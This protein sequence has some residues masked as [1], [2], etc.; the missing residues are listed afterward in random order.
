MAFTLAHMA[1]ALPL[2]RSNNKNHSVRWLQFDALLI[3]TMLPDMHYY[4]Y[5]SSSFSRQSHEWVG[6]LTYNLP[7]GLVFFT[8]WNWGL[9]PAAF[10]LVQPFLIKRAAKSFNLKDV[11]RKNSRNKVKRYFTGYADRYWSFAGIKK[12]VLHKVKSFY[13]PV[14]LSLVFG[15][16]THLIWDGITHADGSIARHIDWL[17][18]PLY[19]FPFKGTSIAR[20][21]QYL[22]SIVGLGALFWFVLLR[23]KDWQINTK[24]VAKETETDTIVTLVFSKKQ[25][26]IIIASMTTLC[27]VWGIQA[28]LNWY[29]SLTSSP[30]RFAAGV[31]VSLLKRVTLLCVSYAALYHLT[32]FL[33]NT[34]RQYRK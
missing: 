29:P 12:R 15:A 22:S 5:I 30:Y 1:A 18:Y 23:A 34:Y 16:F 33:Q 19:F 20:L 27:L 24:D 9:K 8:V 14:V 2:Y 32:Y 25:S 7:L 3:G 13:L 26:V 10:A 28:V 21:L 6:L 31:S 17:Q 11:D 4:T